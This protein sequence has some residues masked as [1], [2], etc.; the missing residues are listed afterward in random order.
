M[1][2]ILIKNVPA[3]VHAWLK[4]EAARNRRSMTQQ[5]VVILEACM[6]RPKAL[7]FPVPFPIKG[8]PLTL[9]EID[10]AKKAGR[11]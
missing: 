6:G 7:Y 8:A 9:S 1:S 4:D 10:V 2:D 3:P 5:A 11:A